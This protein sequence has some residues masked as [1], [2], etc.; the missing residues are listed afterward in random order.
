[1][2]AIFEIYVVTVTTSSVSV[3]WYIDSIILFACTKKSRSTVNS[4]EHFPIKVYMEEHACCVPIVPLLRSPTPFSK[5]IWWLSCIFL[6]ITLRRVCLPVGH[7]PATFAFSL[8]NCTWKFTQRR[9][10]NIWDICTSILSMIFC[11]HVATSLLRTN[12]LDFWVP[13]EL[14]AFSLSTQFGNFHL[15]HSVR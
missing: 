8:T 2:E 7:E 13:A 3:C 11:I 10:L 15:I 14:S 4:Q 12:L 6:R 9:V 1:M 5:K